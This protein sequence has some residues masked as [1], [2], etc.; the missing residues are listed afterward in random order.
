V[1]QIIPKADAGTGDVD[2]VSIAKEIQFWVF[3]LV[4]VI[5]M[6]YIIWAGAKLLWAPGNMEQVSTAM[7]SL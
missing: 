4:G 5:A 7:K 3:A 2:Y 6:I 1:Q